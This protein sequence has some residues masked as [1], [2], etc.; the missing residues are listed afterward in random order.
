M[1]NAW[2]RQTRAAVLALF[3]LAAGA[4]LTVFGPVE[5][6]RAVGTYNNAGIADKALTYLGQNG[7]MACQDAGKSGG[8][9]CKQFVNCIV[10]MVS[11]HTQYPVDPNGDYQNSYNYVGG[12]E[13]ASA[14]NAVK[15]DIIQYGQ[16]DADAAAEHLHTAIIVENKGGGLFSVVDANYHYDHMVRQ[17]DYRPPSGSRFW[18]MG[19]V[20]GNSGSSDGNGSTSSDGFYHGT[21]PDGMLV[22]N[23]VG[24]HW[25]VAAGGSLFWFDKTNPAISQPLINQRDAK[26]GWMTVPKMHNDDI[27]AI[28]Y[29]FGGNRSHVPRDNLFFYEL[30]SNTQYVVMYGY[31]FS[32]AS[33]DEVVYLNGADKAVMVPPNAA[34]R[35]SGMPSIPN[36]VLLQTRF[37]PAIYHVVNGSAFWANNTT[38]VDCIEK[39]KGGS[40][41]PVPASLMTSW[42]LANRVSADVT[43]CSFPNTWALYGPGGAQRW[44]IDGAN[45]YTRYKYGSP[46]ALRCRL[47]ASPTEVQLPDAAGINTPPEGAVLDCP[48]NS[49]VRIAG[50]GE[51]F[52]VDGGILHYIGSPATLTCLTWGNNG[53]VVDIDG[54]VVAMTPRGDPLSCQFEGRMLLAPGGQVDLVKDGS[55]RH[56]INPAIRDCLKGRAGTG[57]P[58]PV[59]QG[60]FNSYTDSGISAFCPYLA[61]TRFVQGS[62]QPEVWRVFPDGTR[63]HA[64]GFCVS[65]PLTTN[66]EQFHVYVVPAGEVDGHALRDPS[67]FHASAENCGAIA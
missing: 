21:P 54:A 15:G 61:S 4:G 27:H 13:V 7:T 25:Y 47:G 5:S 32:I 39:V 63:Q 43:H 66:L 62:G 48:N 42:R 64:D 1:C 31:A 36:D 56:V 37:D 2:R 24:G 14:D 23:E 65:D 16:T 46:L 40:L 33:A 51:V 19:T 41:Q 26:L 28:E 8:D 22:E 17:H 18:R 30:G 44:W 53:V 59:D 60:L 3:V 49:F 11:S 29:G 12:E 35:L 52:R 20:S 50:N 6:A 45:P 55:R 38:V 34:S 10:Y 9:Q 58:V 57:D 67:V